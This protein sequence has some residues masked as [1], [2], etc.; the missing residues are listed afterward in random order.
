A[1]L[2]QA[3]GE[4]GIN[5]DMISTSEIRISVVTEEAR[6]D[7]AVRA[8][9]SAFGLDGEQTEAAVYGGTGRCA[10]TTASERQ[11]SRTT[12]PGAA[13]AR[14]A[15]AASPAAPAPGPAG[16]SAAWAAR[17]ASCDA[18]CCARRRRARRGTAAAACAPAHAAAAGQAQTRVPTSAESAPGRAEL[19]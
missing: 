7:D 18:G 14:G 6:L 1:T 5:I 9:H 8:S 16:R 12:R 2:F 3:L 11:A 4:G 10:P 17:P 19:A 15:H 13:P